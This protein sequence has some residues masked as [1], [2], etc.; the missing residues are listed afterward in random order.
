MSEVCNIK[1]LSVMGLIDMKYFRIH[2]RYHRYRWCGGQYLWMMYYAEHI[3]VIRIKY[4]MT[5]SNGS[6]FCVTGPLWRE[7]TGHRWIPITKASDAELWCF[8][9]SAHWTNGWINNREAGDLGRHRA[10]YDV[11]VVISWKWKLWRHDLWLASICDCGTI[12][13]HIMLQFVTRH[14]L[15]PKV[16]QFVTSVIQWF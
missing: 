1:C 15:W 14:D 7:F 12:C 2:K 16:L 11:I 3:T 13:D 5:S 4:V 10:H 6:I 8:L 9:W